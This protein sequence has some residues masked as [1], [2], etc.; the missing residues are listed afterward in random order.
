MKMTKVQEFN[1]ATLQSLSYTEAIPIWPTGLTEPSHEICPKFKHRH[2]HSTSSTHCNT[3]ISILLCKRQNSFRKQFVCEFVSSQSLVD[4][5][6]CARPSP[7][8]FYCC[9]FLVT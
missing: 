7:F 4:F 5:H 8:Y 2:T 6:Q 1:R 9:F 3:I